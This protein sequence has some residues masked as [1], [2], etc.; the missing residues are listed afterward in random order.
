MQMTRTLEGFQVTEYPVEKLGYSICVIDINFEEAGVGYKKSNEIL[1]KLGL[2]PVPSQKFFMAMLNNPELLDATKTKWSA[3]GYLAGEGFDKDGTFA[4]NEK[5]G[6]LEAPKGDEP[7]EKLVRTRAGEGPLLVYVHR[8]NFAADR[9][10][11]FDLDAAIL[12]GATWMVFGIKP[13]G[14]ARV[15]KERRMK[16]GETLE[17]TLRDGKKIQIDDAIAF[18]IVKGAKRE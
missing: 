15:A 16:K 11:R 2:G 5:T 9:G 8:D 1:N 18:K 7:A 12:P 3:D 6:E 17:V 13:I 4:I 10:R 14:A